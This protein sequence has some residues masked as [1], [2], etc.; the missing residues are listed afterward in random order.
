[1][2]DFSIPDDLKTAVSSE[3]APLAVETLALVRA[4]S[5]LV[6]EDYALGP[7]EIALEWLTAQLRMPIAFI[8]PVERKPSG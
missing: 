7:P 6:N 4:L 8:G 1:M 2:V 5:D 3:T